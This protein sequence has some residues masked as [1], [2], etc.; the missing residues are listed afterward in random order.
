MTLQ[1]TTSTYTSVVVLFNYCHER[2]TQFW[3]SQCEEKRKKKDFGL[4]VTLDLVLSQCI[5]YN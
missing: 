1:C 3:T 4:L 2:V 5:W